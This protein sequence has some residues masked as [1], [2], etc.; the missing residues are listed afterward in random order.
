[1][2]EAVTHCYATA[3]SKN[4]TCTRCF[5]I[6]LV[7]CNAA[8]T[9]TGGTYLQWGRELSGTHTV[10][11]TKHLRKSRWMRKEA[12]QGGVTFRVTLE[13]TGGSGRRCGLRETVRGGKWTEGQIGRGGGGTWRIRVIGS[14]DWW[15]VS[16][17][18]RRETRWQGTVCQWHAINLVQR[19]SRVCDKTRCKMSVSEWRNEGAVSGVKSAENHRFQRC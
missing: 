18:R 3:W 4:A 6:S 7:N 16:T 19:L 12:E 13:V 10:K 17:D 5:K 15:Q 14:L 9:E 1:M 8:D 11:R 2:Y